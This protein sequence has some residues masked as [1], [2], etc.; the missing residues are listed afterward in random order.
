LLVGSDGKAKF[1]INQSSAYKNIQVI[2]LDF[3]PENEEHTEEKISF[4]Y[5]ELTKKV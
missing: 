1:A 4:K 2:T 5:A 3:A